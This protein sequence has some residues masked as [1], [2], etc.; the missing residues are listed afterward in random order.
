MTL[1][2]FSDEAVEEREQI[3]STDD[4]GTLDR[5]GALHPAE[6]V[7]SPATGLSSVE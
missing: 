1:C 4:H 2:R 6:S 3:V 7:G 5:A